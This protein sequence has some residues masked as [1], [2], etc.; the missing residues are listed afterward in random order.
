PPNLPDQV[1]ASNASSLVVLPDPQSP[2]GYGT[3]MV[4]AGQNAALR[5]E[6]GETWSLGLSL[7]PVS[8][9]TATIALTY[10]DTLFS[11]RIYQIPSLPLD[12]FSNI[13]FSDLVER[14]VGPDLR[15]YVCEHSHFQGSLQSCLTTPIDALVDLR[16]RNSERLQT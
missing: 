13:Q 6:S 7:S 15:S 16:L 11:D 8:H 14:R 9:P 10:F 12:V 3:A 5:P 2:S 4:W 1:E